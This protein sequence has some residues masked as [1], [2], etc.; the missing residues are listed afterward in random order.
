MAYMGHKTKLMLH[1]F[2][3]I[4]TMDPLDPLHGPFGACGSPIK[5]VCVRAKNVFTLSNL[6]MAAAATTPVCNCW[7]REAVDR[8]T[9]VD[10]CKRTL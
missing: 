9:N 7:H 3:L 1:C 8:N 2:I 5:N 6:L 10:D 4:A